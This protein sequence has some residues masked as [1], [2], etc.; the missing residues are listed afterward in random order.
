MIPYTIWLQQRLLGNPLHSFPGPWLEGVNHEECT[1]LTIPPFL[2]PPP[3]RARPVSRLRGDHDRLDVVHAAESDAH[4]ADRFQPVVRRVAGV[5]APGRPFAEQLFLVDRR[6]GV[7]QMVE[8]SRLD[9]YYW[10]LYGSGNKLRGSGCGVYCSVTCSSSAIVYVKGDVEKMRA[11]SGQK[12]QIMAH[13]TLACAEVVILLPV[14]QLWHCCI[15]TSELHGR[16]KF[17]RSRLD[18]RSGL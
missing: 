8:L 5:K 14:C 2:Q 17:P 4:P 11:S 18:Q 16:W 7:Y 9:E 15:R 10:V 3:P 13:R 12:E 6:E 1:C